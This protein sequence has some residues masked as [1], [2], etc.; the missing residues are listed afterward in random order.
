MILLAASLHISWWTFG[1]AGAAIAGLVVM[2]RYGYNF[3]SAMRAIRCWIAGP[4]R[5]ALD[6]KKIRG[7]SDTEAKNLP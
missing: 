5:P 4:D 3:M 2:E 1:I 7:F 6:P